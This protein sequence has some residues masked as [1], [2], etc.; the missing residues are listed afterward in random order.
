MAPGRKRKAAPK[1]KTVILD[2]ADVDEESAYSDPNYAINN[3]MLMDDSLE[4]FDNVGG[5]ADDTVATIF[6][7]S[8]DRGYL[9]DPSFHLREATGIV[10]V[11]CEGPIEEIQKKSKTSS[12]QKFQVS[13][14]SNGYVRQKCEK[15]HILSK[16]ASSPCRPH[17]S[18]KIGCSSCEADKVVSEESPCYSCLPCQYNLCTDC[19]TN[20]AKKYKYI[21]NLDLI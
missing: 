18:G 4:I 10:R 20:L 16:K 19:Y 17:K 15:G 13:E 14:H 12:N 9:E 6:F 7:N 3:A 1:G 5:T 11:T 2:V 8:E 21:S